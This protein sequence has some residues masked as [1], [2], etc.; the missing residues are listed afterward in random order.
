MAAKDRKEHK[1]NHYFP[2]FGR[3]KSESYMTLVK[4][5]ELKGCRES[6]SKSFAIFAF[7]CGKFLSVFGPS[8]FPSL[9]W[10]SVAQSIPGT[11]R[12]IGLHGSNGRNESA[13]RA[14]IPKSAMYP[15][16]LQECSRDRRGGNRPIPWRG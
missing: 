1:E 10:D 16:G 7:F 11:R 13:H 3:P 4:E 14:A 5:K 9:L 6:Q 15:I 2:M 8:A 12:T